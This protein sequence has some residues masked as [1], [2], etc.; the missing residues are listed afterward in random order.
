MSFGLNKMSTGT[1]QMLFWGFAIV[2]G[3]SMST[4]LL[5]YTG[6]SVAQTFFAT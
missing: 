3:L 1:L 5:V 6:A 2:M 4:I